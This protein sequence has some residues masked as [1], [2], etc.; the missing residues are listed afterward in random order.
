[1][2]AG[3]FPVTENYITQ[4]QTRDRVFSRLPL[5]FEIQNGE[6]D[7]LFHWVFHTGGARGEKAMR[8]SHDVTRRSLLRTAAVGTVALASGI[9]NVFGKTEQNVDDFFHDFTADWVHHDPDLAT[10]TRYF[11]GEE[12]RRL[13]RELTPQTAAWRHDRIRRAKRGLAQLRGFDRNRMTES[14]RVSAGLLQWQLE[15]VVGEEAYLDYTFPLEQFRGANINLVNTMTVVRS[16]LFETDAENYVAALGQVGTRMEE[17]IAESQRLAGKRIL[18]PR[19]ILE[20]T[21]KQMQEFVATPPAQNPFVTAFTQKMAGVNAISDAK[22]EEFR[23]QTEKTVSAQIYPAWQKAIAVLES[24]TTHASDDAGLWRFKNGA[25]IY[26]YDLKLFTTTNL[27]ADQIHELG[28]Q[29]VALIERRMD[30]LLR[31]LGRTEGSVKD[32]IAKLSEDLTY[33]NPSSELSRK[34]I[35]EDI[36]GILADAQK[37][38][39][40]LFDKQ[41]KSPVIAQPYPRFREASAAASYATPAPDGSRPGIFQYPLRLDKMTK[42]GLRT[43]VYHETVP[44]HHYQLALELEDSSLPR[45]RQILVFGGISALIEG[46]GLYAEHLA[47][48]S[49]WYDG[50]PQGLLGQLYWEL[51]RARRLVVDTGLHAKHWTRQQGI[52]YG[53]EPSEV[54]RYVVLPGQ[55]CSYMI[56]ELKILELRDKAKKEL[57]DRFSLQQFHDAVL[58]TGT[59]PLDMLER[60]VDD[61]IRSAGGLR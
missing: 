22:R 57:G 53:I 51:F 30:S 6:Y 38:S 24:Q 9:E 16:L 52:D 61:Y 56:G 12:Q 23:A 46:W 4:A 10:R 25:E 2:N 13:E 11:S 40:L 26:N 49:G 14:Q 8:H 50:D 3:R 29:H 55:A 18:P 45:F 17:A 7:V 34:Q 19:F 27:T 33:P 47:A 35:M 43:T 21:I 36:K 42:F 44:G 31:G 48:E 39:A 58:D 60:H 54:D 5:R 15:T 1:V 41:P 28:L 37:R 20:T 59:V 32:R